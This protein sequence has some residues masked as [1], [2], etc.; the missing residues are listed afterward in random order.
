MTAVENAHMAD[1]GRRSEP[2][3]HRP[4]VS[5]GAAALS[6]AQLLA[7]SRADFE[8]LF[9][10]YAL[11]IYRYCARRIGQ[12]EADDLVSVAQVAQYPQVIFGPCGQ[13]W[14][15]LG[16]HPARIGSPTA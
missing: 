16:V 13:Q 14:Q 8:V 3:G 5:W 15:D 4:D 6:D 11:E 7:G 9:D 1:W 2:P 12:D 10:R